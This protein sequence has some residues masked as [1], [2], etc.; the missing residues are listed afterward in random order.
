[1]R[2][3]IA[4]VLAAFVVSVVSLLLVILRRRMRTEQYS[5][6]ME[7]AALSGRLK[8]SNEELRE[9]KGQISQQEKNKTVPKVES[10]ATFAEE[11]ICRQILSVCSDKSNPIKSTIPVSSYADIALTDAQKAQL[12]DAA[13]RHYGPLLGK[14]KHQHPE[15][16]EKDFLYCQLCL[17]GLD[18]AQIAV[19]LQNTISTVWERENRLKRIFGTVDKVSVFLFGFM[20]N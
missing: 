20:K 14:L 17:L 16:K 19:L 3:G 15:L 5:H 13:M 2:W 12:K 8:R 9:L 10:A 4:L 7:Q 18:N 1:M 11:P 6:K